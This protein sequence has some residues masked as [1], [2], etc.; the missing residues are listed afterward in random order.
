MDS[1]E[2]TTVERCQPGTC[3]VLW[4][5]FPR[6]VLIANES[7]GPLWERAV[8]QLQDRRLTL[9][10]DKAAP[11]HRYIQKVWL[12]DKLLDQYWI[13]HAAIAEGG[14]LR[15]EMGAVPATGRYHF[16]G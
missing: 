15:F 1:M 7:T 14:T 9:I 16:V 11:N 6:P 5:C 4:G 13:Q 10:A 3:S 8:I 2:T 12:N